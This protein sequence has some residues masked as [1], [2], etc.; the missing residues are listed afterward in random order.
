MYESFFGLNQAPF[1][2]APDPRYLF[3]S[4]RHREALAHLLY[5]LKGSGGFVLL[6]GEIGA[7]KT[8][9]CRCFLQQVP[10]NCHAA[11]IFNPKLNALELLQSICDEF[12]VKATPVVPAQPTVKDYIDPLNRFL[13]GAHA[14]GQ[15]CVLV[16]DEAQNLAPDVLEQLRLLTNLETDQRKLLQIILIG[17]PELRDMVAQPEMEQLAQ[18]VTAR[19]HLGPLDE[20]ESARYV[21]HRLTVAG[22]RGVLPFDRAALARIYELS[23]GVPRRI[24]L[25]ADRALLGAYAQGNAVVG[26]DTVDRAGTEVFVRR[27]RGGAQRRPV[28][29]GRRARA[30]PWM[31]AALALTLLVLALGVW[32]VVRGGWS[33][34]LDRGALGAS[35][36]DDGD[37][38]GLAKANIGTMGLVSGQVSE[39]SGVDATAAS[40]PLAGVPGTDSANQAASAGAPR[41]GGLQSLQVPTLPVFDMAKH[42]ALLYSDRDAAWTDLAKLWVLALPPG[43]PCDMIERQQLACYRSDTGTL[44]QVKL[45]DRPVVVKLF[46]R[47]GRSGRALLLGL[48]AKTAR[49]A[50]DQRQWVM[51]IDAFESLWRGEFGTLWRMPA[52]YEKPLRPGGSGAA[53][54]ALAQSLATLASA[55]PNADAKDTNALRAEGTTRSRLLAFQRAQG[56]PVDGMAGPTTFMLLN[57]ALGVVEPRLARE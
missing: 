4:E 47:S 17:Q 48:N 36:A 35:A 27:A 25:L 32:G 10:D 34:D 56:L 26:A 33:F 8:T 20:V 45:M 54:Q 15:Q 38:P 7:G 51:P 13:L 49:L 40:S 1:S 2:I 5:G 6:S 39:L 24:N 53:A 50:V 21:A 14:D 29:K 37:K 41:S 19:Y 57:R 55:K 18:R 11:Y 12:R 22:R 46:D 43:D 9:V 52:G 31:P 44:A 3:M 16:I 42:G 30:L 23:G 28:A